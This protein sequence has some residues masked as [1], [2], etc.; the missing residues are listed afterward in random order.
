MRNNRVN[1]L[2][3]LSMSFSHSRILTDKI[4]L[5]TSTV[6]FF[7]FLYL[8]IDIFFCEDDIFIA[9]FLTFALFLTGSDIE[10]DDT[11]ISLLKNLLRDS[12]KSSVLKIEF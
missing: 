3:F 4:I 2:N 8:I 7:S 5:F 9:F 12:V 10:S 1:D 6:F 11:K